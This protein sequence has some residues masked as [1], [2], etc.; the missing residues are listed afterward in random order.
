M[1]RGLSGQSGDLYFE[2]FLHGFVSPVLDSWKALGVTHMLTVIFFCRSFHFDR[3]TLSSHP[4]E[5]DFSFPRLDLLILHDLLEL[6]SKK[7]FMKNSNGFY[8]QDFFKIVI[9]NIADI[10]K[11]AQIKVLRQQF[12]EFAQCVGWRTCKDPERELTS[13]LALGSS[14]NGIG[15]E[16]SESGGPRQSNLNYVLPSDAVH[17]NVLEAINSTLN[18]LEKHYMDRDLQVRLDYSLRSLTLLSLTPSAA[19]RKLYCADLGG[20]GTVQS[21][22]QSSTNNKAKNA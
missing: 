6:Y 15:A 11:A 9:E 5:F 1:T 19:H 16:T 22:A 13:R 2:K 10:D 20:I 3:V 7:S 12:W 18:I 17:G 4:G 14:S 8:Q 21:Q